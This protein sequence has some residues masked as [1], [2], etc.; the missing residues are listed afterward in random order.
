MC[1]GI[2][3]EEA[4][5]RINSTIMGIAIHNA[6][7][8]EGNDA[9]QNLAAGVR[10]DAKGLLGTTVHLGDLV[11]SSVLPGLFGVKCRR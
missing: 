10:R 3:S 6:T 2:H 4:L 1:A 9:S 7:S 11:R 5:I 8:T